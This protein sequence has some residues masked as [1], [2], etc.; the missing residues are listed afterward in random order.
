[1]NWSGLALLMMKGAVYG[2][3]LAGPLVVL[4]LWLIGVV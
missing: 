4:Y 1:M 2:M 3:A